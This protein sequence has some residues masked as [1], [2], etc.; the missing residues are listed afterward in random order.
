[1]QTLGWGSIVNLWRVWEAIAE[2]EEQSFYRERV[3]EY[4]KD[5]Y[6]DDYIGNQDGRD[7]REWA[8]DKAFDDM[9]NMDEVK[10]SLEA[11]R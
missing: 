4:L 9:I 6:E 2:Q 8:H 11:E 3:K 1:M 7:R 5:E 10:E